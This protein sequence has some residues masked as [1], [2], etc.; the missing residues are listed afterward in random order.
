[1]ARPVGD[2]PE[3]QAEK[4]KWYVPERSPTSCVCTPRPNL[5]SLLIGT[6]GTRSGACRGQK[7]N[8]DISLP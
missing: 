3:V 8:D 6:R 1:M 2:G 4:E 5:L 7:R